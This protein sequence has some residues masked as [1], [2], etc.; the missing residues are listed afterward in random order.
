MYYKNLCQ[1]VS[2]IESILFWITYLI[3][4]FD[5]RNSVRLHKR[6]L[7]RRK[8]QICLRS[9][10]FY[11]NKKYTWFTFGYR[12]WD[13]FWLHILEVNYKV[14][15]YLGFGDN[16]ITWIKILNTQ[17]KALILQCGFLSEQFDIDRGCRQGDPIA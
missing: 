10:V 15:E 9:N 1:D 3:Y 7:N 6:S 2:D 16:I 11:W 13:S 8:Y 4:V 17:I 12:F 5:I 14:L